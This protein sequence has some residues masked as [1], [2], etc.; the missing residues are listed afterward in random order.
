MTFV[1]FVTE[2]L[3]LGLFRERLGLELFFKED[4]LGLGLAANAK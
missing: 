1:G 4:S 2:K 3:G